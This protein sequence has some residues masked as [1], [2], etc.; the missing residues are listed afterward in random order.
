MVAPDPLSYFAEILRGIESV[1]RPAKLRILVC[2][3][4]EDADNEIAEVEAL[5]QR[6]DGLIV[7]SSLSPE[8]GLAYRKLIKD[9][10]KLVLVDRLMEN[11]RCPTVSTDNVM[12][13]MIATEHLIGLGHRRS[14]PRRVG[15]GGRGAAGGLQGGARET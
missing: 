10:L 15:I 6:T 12:V 14:P 7:A 4:Y 5:R 1:A 8:Q 2:N 3:T 9:G 11:L 13:G